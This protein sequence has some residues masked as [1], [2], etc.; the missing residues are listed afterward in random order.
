MTRNWQVY[1]H[2]AF[3][4]LGALVAW[5]LLGL[6]HT[7]AW[8]IYLAN[9]FIGAGI[10]ALIGGML[11]L[12]EGLLVRR[13]ILWAVV[14]LVGGAFFG[15]L[16]GMVGLLVGGVVFTWIEGGLVARVLGWVLFGAFMGAGLGLVH[17]SLR[18]AAYGVVGGMLGGF[19]GGLFYEVLTQLFLKWSDTAQMILSAVGLVIL[20][21]L[22]GAMIPLSVSVIGGL[23]SERGL[24]I[25]LN[26]PRQGMEI[27][28]VGPA[29]VGSSDACEVYVPD[30]H[31]ERRQA[32]LR[33]GPRGFEMANIGALQPLFVNESLLTPGRSTIL[34]DG[35]L[36]Q[37]GQISLRFQNG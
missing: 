8:N 21:V 1:Y 37:V 14:G 6:I 26:G 29:L 10:G 24:I 20:G 28:V 33:P 22:L 34:A 3:G 9:G 30:K 16:G 35:A 4:A 32:Q 19:L 13:S 18:R 12:V 23:R 25:Y 27:E 15:L 31:V 17:L 36:I 5:Q 11:G 2:A 7:A